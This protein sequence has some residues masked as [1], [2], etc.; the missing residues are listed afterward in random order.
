MNDLKFALRQL[1][2]N[3]GFTSVAVLT[4]AIGIGANTAIFSVVHGV[5]WKPLPFRDPEQL[6]RV[7]ENSEGQPKF[8]M[9]AGDFLDYRE[10]NS[11]LAGLAIYTRNDL[12]L[13][14]DDDAE[15]VAALRV[16]SGFFDVLQV[17]PILGRD[18]RRE[19]ESPSDHR[20]VI[21]SHKLW[22]R[23]FNGDSGVVGQ[24]VTLAGELFTVVGVMPP[25]LQHIG[26][27]YRSMPYGETV[28]VWFPLT[29][30]ANEDRNSHFLNAVGRLKPDVHIS[31]ATADLNVIAKRLAQKFPDT[32]GNFRIA[33]ES[34]REEI[35][36]QSRTMLLVLFGA[37]LSVLL[38]ACV[39]VANLLMARAAARATE[40]A[41]RS[42]VGAS[43]WH[44]LRQ[45]LTESL[46]LAGFGGG[47][48][49]LLAQGGLILLGKFGPQD[50]PRLQTVHIDGRVLLFSF[51]LALATG[52]LFGLVPAIIAG[53]SDLNELLKAGGRAG[54][55]RSRGLVR[56]MLVVTEV[57][58]SLLVLVGTVL[59][60]CSFWKLQATDHGFKP[61]HVLT[62][63]ISLPYRDY[64]DRTNIVR[65]QTQLLTR[66]S[67]LSGVESVGLTSDLPWTGYDENSWFEIQGKTFPPGTGPGGRYHFVSPDYFRTV[68][69]PLVAGRF[70]DSN[71]HLESPRVVLINQRLA[72]RY[73]PGENPV[74]QRITF[75]ANPKEN[76]WRTIV[77]I[78][79]DVKDRPES[80]RTRPAFYLS[81]AQ[82][83]TRQAQLAVR[84]AGATTGLSDEIRSAIREIDRGVPMSN[85]KLLE[86]ISAAAVAGRRFTFWLVGGFAVI[87]MALAAIGIYG[88]L[89]YMVTQRTREIGVRMAL[90]AQTSDIIRLTLRQGMRPTMIGVVL[91]LLGALG[92]T[93]FMTSLLFGVSATD[94]A[95]LALS[96]FILTIIAL[97]PCWVP[98][99]RAAAIQPTEA[100]RAE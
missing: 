72:Q 90:G 56:E 29:F 30:T 95:I 60:V 34:L 46:L 98:A 28:D 5:L 51:G 6:I 65:F 71:D 38:I 59:L 3:P 21:L 74:G 69:V 18:F 4:L 43:R 92:T 33:V 26:G 94:P 100:L 36:G 64:I 22:E 86:T 12:E 78:V 9:S 25:G 24:K 89:S 84:T 27:S 82:S 62:A 67:A 19:D 13:S 63:T 48:G 55:G 54:S 53:K 52:I 49:I 83:P 14:K 45:L 37:V 73:W 40:I 66:L 35:V 32:N 77:G 88:V 61:E 23:R 96:A 87:A 44:I 10:Q 97:F 93:R 58:L 17:K 50:L 68:G 80:S 20:V 57:A 79:G 1:L 41:V 42:A 81:M 15:L 91:G 47:I 99:R 11:T 70:F 31:Q 39:N 7:F 8:P 16:S 85:V 76:D 2:K 75:T